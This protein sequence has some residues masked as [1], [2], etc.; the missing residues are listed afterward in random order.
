[1]LIKAFKKFSIS[2]KQNPASIFAVNGLAVVVGCLGEYEEALELLQSV[3]VS[4][5]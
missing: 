2:L 5:G 1:L 3:G 4:I